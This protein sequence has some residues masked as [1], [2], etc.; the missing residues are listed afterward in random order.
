MTVRSLPQAHGRSLLSPSSS[1]SHLTDLPK[2]DLFLAQVGLMRERP[3]I[4]NTQ[5][6]NINE[7]FS[8]LRS[9]VP[10]KRGAAPRLALKPRSA[11]L[12]GGHF[13]TPVPPSWTSFCRD[14]VLLL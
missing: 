2:Y 6:S 9:S 12:R 14:A 5:L 11:G 3:G 4:Q 10:P 13:V 1:F 7:A 8:V